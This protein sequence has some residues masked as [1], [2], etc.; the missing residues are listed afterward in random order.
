MRSVCLRHPGLRE[1]EP[2]GGKGLTQE[3]RSVLQVT[4]HWKEA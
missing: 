1:L 4:V 3:E 2:S